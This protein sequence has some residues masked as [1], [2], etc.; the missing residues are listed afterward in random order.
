MT[1]PGPGNYYLGMSFLPKSVPGKWSV[2]LILTFFSLVIIGRML[3]AVDQ[4]G[5]DVAVTSGLPI[6]AGI[7]AMVAGIAS[8]ITGMV[9]LI[10]LREKAL[11]V[12][13]A[14]IEGGVLIL[15]TAGMFLISGWFH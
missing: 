10:K 1:L 2:W 5:S 3:V 9:S 11:S 8:F 7:L 14:A 6:F 12:F 15:M 13:L 4:A